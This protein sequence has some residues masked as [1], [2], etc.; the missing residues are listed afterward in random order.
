MEYMTASILD[1]VP[2]MRACKSLII[3]HA[4]EQ[5]VILNFGDAGWC[6]IS[7]NLS[8]KQYLL[9]WADFDR[10]IIAL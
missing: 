6:A 10:G 8:C 4:I 2:S 7:V 9:T 3:F 1:L 5:G